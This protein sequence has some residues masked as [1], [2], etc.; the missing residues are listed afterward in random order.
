MPAAIPAQADL[1][2]PRAQSCTVG[3]QLAKIAV[4]VADGCRADV[5]QN[6]CAT[7]T[8]AG[9]ERYSGRCM[10]NRCAALARYNYS[11]SSCAACAL[12]DQVEHFMPIRHKVMHRMHW[13]CCAAFTYDRV[14]PAAFRRTKRPAG[15]VVSPAGLMGGSEWSAFAHHSFLAVVF[16]GIAEVDG[17]IRTGAA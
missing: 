11:Q 4:L 13:I 15:P 9:G 12:I 6:R 17:D 10:E 7:A 3:P 14:Q 2:R 1:T 8:E 16:D 5:A